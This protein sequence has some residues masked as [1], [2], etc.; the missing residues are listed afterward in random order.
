MLLLGGTI[1]IAV[2]VWF[3]SSYLILFA[4]TR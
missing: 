1:V 3:T 4:R 2:L